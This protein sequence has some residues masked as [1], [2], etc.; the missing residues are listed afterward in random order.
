[1]KSSASYK[2]SGVDLAV[3]NQAKKSIKELVRSTFSKNVLREIGLF[4]GFY[5]LDLQKYKKP[6]L[7][8][9]IDGVGT[10][11][12]IAQMMGV[13]DSI[14]VDLVNHCSNDIAVCGAAPIYFLDYIAADK[15]NVEMV[16]GIVKGMAS[17]CREASC[18]LI[19]GETAEMPGIYSTNNF[20]VA[21]CIVGLVEKDEIIDG[22]KIE[23]GDI[24]IGVASNGLHTNGFSLV[25]KLFFENKKYAVTEFFPDLGSTLGEELLRTHRSY[26]NLIKQVKS[27]E[28]LHGI[29][30]ITGGGIIGNTIRLLQTGLELRIDWGAWQI[31]AIF[32]LIQKE[33]SIDPSEMRN[34]F[35]MGIGLVLVAREEDVDLFLNACKS[36]GDK[37][38][39]IGSV[40][41]K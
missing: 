10:K 6:V 22:S 39:V 23:A 19:G 30:H 14:G 37:A 34:V 5:E 9:S 18:A 24:L 35:N 16:T 31:P 32:D 41:S 28:T 38:F 17:A 20:D 27:I 40:I 33:G 26:L 4:G 2:E 15:L 13:Y 36:S 8:S 29:S 11:V 25:R 12:K 7:V 3:S 1:M 21:G